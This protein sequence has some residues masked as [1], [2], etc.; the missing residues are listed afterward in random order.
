MPLTLQTHSWCNECL[1]LFRLDL[2]N[3]VLVVLQFCTVAS[4]R[5]A[6]P[7]WQRPLHGDG[8]N[9]PK[10]GL[11]SVFWGFIFAA[12]LSC[13]SIACLSPPRSVAPPWTR[14][15]DSLLSTSTPRHDAHQLPPRS[16]LMCATAF[17][18]ASTV[19]NHQS[20]SLYGCRGTDP[21]S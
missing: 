11:C 20:T 13:Q 4:W 15:L 19:I 14:H 3:A 6:V 9:A 18:T 10:S 8:P 17:T 5:Q 1:S 2:M 21:H 16:V 12:A 7:A